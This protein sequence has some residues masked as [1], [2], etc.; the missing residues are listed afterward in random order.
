M[1]FCIAKYYEDT[2][3]NFLAFQYLQQANFYVKSP[4]GPVLK[5]LNVPLPICILIL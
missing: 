4:C 1:K 2:F 5:H 3:L